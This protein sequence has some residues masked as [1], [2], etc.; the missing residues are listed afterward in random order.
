[1]DVEDKIDLIKSFAEEI[2][3]EDELRELFKTKKKIVA[4]DGF[5]PSGQIHIAQGL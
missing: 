4:Y 5:E 1:M 3:K 2:I